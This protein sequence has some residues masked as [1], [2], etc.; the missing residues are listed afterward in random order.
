M[1]RRH[2]KKLKTLQKTVP[3]RKRKTAT[4][5]SKHISKYDR[6]ILYKGNNGQSIGEHERYAYPIYQKDGLS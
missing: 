4:E 3:K 6:V 5:K 2:R 1:N